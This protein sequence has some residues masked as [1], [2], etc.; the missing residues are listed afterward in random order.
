MS[1]EQVEKLKKESKAIRE[2]IKEG[3]PAEDAVRIYLDANKKVESGEWVEIYEE[4]PRYATNKYLPQSTM[5]T[6]Y[7]GPKNII[8]EEIIKKRKAVTS[9]QLESL[10]E[11][12]GLIGKTHELV[13]GSKEYGDIAYESKGEYKQYKKT[14]NGWRRKEFEKKIPETEPEGAHPPP[15]SHV[16]H[17]HWELKDMHAGRKKKH[18]KNNLFIGF[19]ILFGCGLAY[20]LLSHAAS[21][22]GYAITKTEKSNIYFSILV[23]VILGL[24]FLF[25]AMKKRIHR[26]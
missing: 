21:I 2:A 17:R 10:C 19:L 15:G 7:W 23:A 13:L 18:A 4:H 24:L 14:N 9:N 16:F 11:E 22:T 25:I 26:N 5:I 20:Y 6:R 1:D 3:V 8:E 12:K